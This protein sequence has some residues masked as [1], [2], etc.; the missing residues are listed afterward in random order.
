V[1]FGKKFNLAKGDQNSLDIV[2]EGEIEFSTA[3]NSESKINAKSEIVYQ[4]PR[5]RMAVFGQGAMT[6]DGKIERSFGAEVEYAFDS[7]GIK[8]APGM[9]VYNSKTNEDRDYN[10]GPEWVYTLYLKAIM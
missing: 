10:F 5:V 9:G 8:L 3:G 1:G 4:G 7:F 2:A 6:F